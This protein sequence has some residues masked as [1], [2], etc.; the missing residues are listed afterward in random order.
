VGVSGAFPINGLQI[1]CRHSPGSL[2]R[3]SE[4]GGLLVEIRGSKLGRCVTS[5]FS[6]PN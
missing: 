4:V 6:S 2:Q 5:F 3:T 1:A